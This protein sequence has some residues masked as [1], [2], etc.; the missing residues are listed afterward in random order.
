[1]EQEERNRRLLANYPVQSEFAGKLVS[2]PVKLY[3][4]T[5]EFVRPPNLRIFVNL[6]Y[7]SEKVMKRKIPK[8]PTKT[9]EKIQTT[10]YLICRYIE[11]LES[12]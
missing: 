5:I 6:R 3:K 8:M 9:S 4:L 1:M 2:Y 11:F 12:A 10:K 7:Y